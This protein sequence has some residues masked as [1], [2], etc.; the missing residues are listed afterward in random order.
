MGI[1]EIEA[2]TDQEVAEVMGATPEEFATEPAWMWREAA[3]VAT[4]EWATKVSTEVE[5]GRA[6]V[7]TDPDRIR[8]RLGGRPR[9]G[10]AAGHGPSTQVRV[11]VSSETR[12]ALEDIA[13]AQGRRLSDVSR[14]ALAEYIARHAG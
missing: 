12:A 13:A 14:E 3:K 9:V 4:D 1:A 8:R 11:R 6:R 7:I 5:S 10:G 2:M